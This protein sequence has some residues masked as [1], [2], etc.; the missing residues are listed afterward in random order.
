MKISLKYCFIAAL[1]F[2]T[3]GCGNDDD[4][5]NPTTPTPAATTG[6]IS[7]SITPANGASMVFLIAGTDT[8]KTSPSGFG[9]F[10]FEEV[11]PGN[12][13]VMAKPFS[14]HEGPGPS[15]VTVTAG[16]TEEVHI[17][18]TKIP[19]DGLMSVSI[20]GSIIQGTPV[21]SAV[22][23]GSVSISN[24]DYLVYI[25]L[26]IISGTGN[27]TN[28]NSDLKVTVLQYPTSA[29]WETTKTLGTA[30]LTVTAFDPNSLKGNA[31][32]SFSAPASGNG[33]TGNKAG[34]NGSLKNTRL[35]R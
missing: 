24:S 10:E 20:D 22:G 30:T 7:G 28:A 2:L 14:D 33:A 27:Y 19:I 26:P 25:D 4:T 18:L 8:L 29:R 23:H 3:A 32:F 5:A 6:N 15:P 35:V 9:T 31:T 1:G 12:Y 13:Q 11:K 17:N 34:T 16:K 21:F